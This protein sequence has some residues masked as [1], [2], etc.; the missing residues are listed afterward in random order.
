MTLT[1]FILSGVTRAM[2]SYLAQ[3]HPDLKL[4]EIEG[5]APKLEHDY[6]GHAKL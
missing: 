1:T 3:H 5:D 6:D 4:E 2:E